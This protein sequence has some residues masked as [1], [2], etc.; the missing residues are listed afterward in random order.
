MKFPMHRRDRTL[1]ISLRCVL[2]LLGFGACGAVVSGAVQYEETELQARRA[3]E[4][5]S[6][7]NVIA[8]KRA[9]T[10]HGCDACHTIPGIAGAAGSVGPSLRGV[11]TRAVI[12]ANSP[13]I[14]LISSPGLPRLNICHPVRPCQINH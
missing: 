2:I 10:A 14:L 11:A 9:V 6:G 4:A 13:T 8:G 7:G 5:M 1:P 12:G 3:A